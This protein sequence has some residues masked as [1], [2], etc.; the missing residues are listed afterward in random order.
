MP[1]ERPDAR[2]ARGAETAAAS[3]LWSIIRLDI[4]ACASRR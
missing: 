3:F 4:C 1:A 2:I